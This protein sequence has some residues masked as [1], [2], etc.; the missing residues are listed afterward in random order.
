MSESVLFIRDT[1]YSCICPLCSLR[2]GKSPKGG[3]R[4]IEIKLCES[5]DIG[6]TKEQLASHLASVRSNS[7]LKK[8]TRQRKAASKKSSSV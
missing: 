5:C 7:H 3:E 1:L 6:L 8:R 4:D 2:H